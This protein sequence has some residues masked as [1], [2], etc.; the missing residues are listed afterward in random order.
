MSGSIAVRLDAS[1]ENGIGH[2]MRCLTLRDALAAGGARVRFISR[3]L[4][5]HLREHLRSRGHE[6]VGEP[7][8]SVFRKLL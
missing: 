2:V 6:C 8:Q 5:V 3:H 4:P 7:A 1:P